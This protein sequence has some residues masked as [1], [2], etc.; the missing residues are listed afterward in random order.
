MYHIHRQPRCQLLFS[1]VP[2]EKSIR[3][4]I[5]QDLN[6]N[7]WDRPEEMATQGKLAMRIAEN[8]PIF[9]ASA[10]RER[11]NGKRGDLTFLREPDGIRTQAIHVGNVKGV[12]CSSGWTFRY[13]QVW[14]PT[15]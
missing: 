9:S 14:C 15:N 2:T 7:D 4:K 10:D 1:I 8:P 11:S 3:E 5:D 6:Q 13:A 12:H